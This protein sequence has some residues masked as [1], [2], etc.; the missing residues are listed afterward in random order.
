MRRKGVHGVYMYF[1]NMLDYMTLFYHIIQSL[2]RILEIFVQTAQLKCNKPRSVHF[3]L[4][5]VYCCIVL[6]DSRAKFFCVFL[7][8][9]LTKAQKD[10][11]ITL[12]GV[13]DTIC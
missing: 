9:L 2:S 6:K 13:A 5:F 11:I 4:S 8:L 3:F 12:A 10:V 7:I 1:G